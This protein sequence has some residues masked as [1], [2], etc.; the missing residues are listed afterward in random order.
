MN[1]AGEF[2]PRAYVTR[3]REQQKVNQA[4]GLNEPEPADDVSQESQAQERR[5]LR[6]R[7][8]GDLHPLAMAAAVASP[9]RCPRPE[10]QPWLE[11]LLK[12]VEAWVQGEFTTLVAS[13]STG[14]GKSFAATWAVAE[15][16]ERSL[17]LPASHVRVGWDELRQM[18]EKIPVLIVDDLGEEGAS[19]WGQKE[20]STLLQNRHDAGRRTLVTTNLSK[21]DIGTRYGER[22]ISRWSDESARIVS[23]AGI[24]L[25]KR[26][27]NDPRAT[28]RDREAGR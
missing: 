12:A 14:R 8:A 24:D 15:I 19:D 5:A 26:M 2:D 21:P 27:A 6:M 10:G 4:F 13:A 23:I 18:A 7:A 25:R 16:Q 9:G 22:L 1:R 17:W 11:K 3:L 28:G 20:V